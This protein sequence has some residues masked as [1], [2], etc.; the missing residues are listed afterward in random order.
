MIKKTYL[1]KILSWCVIAAVA[2]FFGITLADNWSNV[3]ELTVDFNGYTFIGIISFIAAVVVSGVLWGKILEKLSGKKIAIIEA[4]EIHS[5]SWLLKYIPGQ[6]GSYVNKIAWGIKKGI[7]KKTISTSFIYENVL[8]VFAGF[9]LATPIIIVLAENSGLE[10]SFFLPF[11]VLIPL[12][13]VLVR[14]VFRGLLNIIVKL[15]KRAPFKDSDFLDTPK[16]FLYQ[17]HYFLPRILNGI[18]FVFIVQTIIP[19][20]PDMYIGL[21][22]AYILASIVGLLAIFVPGGLGVRESIIVITLSVYVPIEQAIIISLLARLY[23]TIADG[24]VAIIYA[25]LKKRRSYE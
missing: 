19:V 14:P 3:R 20:T 15:A 2:V 12:A 8:M 6:V 4:I 5:A 16:L 10:L 7:S 18:G 17:L 13:I 22:S 24:G 9:A 1:K 11:F 25:V 21:A 23:A